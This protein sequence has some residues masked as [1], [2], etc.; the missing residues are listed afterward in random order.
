MSVRRERRAFT[1]VELL[2]V[3]AI[4]A[5][6]VTLLLPAVFAAREAA[7]RAQ[8]SSNKRQV[9]FAVLQH[10][11]AYNRLP[12]IVDKR[13]QGRYGKTPDGEVS[14]VAGWRF[15]ILPFLE[16]ESINQI[17]QDGDDWRFM[18]RQRP[19]T[20]VKPLAVSVFRCPSDPEPSMFE[21]GQITKRRGREV[22]FDATH[23]SDCMAPQLINNVP[24]MKSQ[25]AGA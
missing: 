23:P 10:V 8:C 16:E 9:A 22:L 14:E 21:L 19:A 12:P 2:V 13:F 3:I 15:T 17:L 18:I 4:I 20:P 5:L 6:L 1:L 24:G 25:Y 11:S 7:R